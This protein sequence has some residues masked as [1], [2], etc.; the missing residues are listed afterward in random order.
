MRQLLEYPRQLKMLNEHLFANAGSF[1]LPAPTTADS[2]HTEAPV[3]LP[4]CDPFAV[5]QGFAVSTLKLL[6]YLT[7]M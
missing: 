3:C 1:P 4:R 5:F 7:I 2:K 6:I